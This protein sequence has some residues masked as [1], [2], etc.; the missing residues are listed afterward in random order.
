[1]LRGRPFERLA[2]LV[3]QFRNRERL[4]REHLV[5]HGGV[6]DEHGF[7]DGRLLQVRRG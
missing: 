1:L 4:S 6:V 3:I 5:P 2:L 7:D